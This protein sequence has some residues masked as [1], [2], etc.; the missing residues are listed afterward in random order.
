MNVNSIINKLLTA[1]ATENMFYKINSF[2]RYYEDKR[3]F[4]TRYQ[5]CQ[6]FEFP[7]EIPGETT[8]KYIEV[9]STYSKIDI[10]KY[11]ASDYKDLQTEKKVKRGENIE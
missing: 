8:K 4:V 11:L 2:K 7:T 1:L 9:L 10:L 3:Q 5:L 6:E